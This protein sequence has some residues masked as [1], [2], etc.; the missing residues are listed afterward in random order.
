[1]MDCFSYY[2]ITKIINTGT[3]SQK[4]NQDYQ[5]TK[6]D[7]LNYLLQGNIEK[8]SGLR[9]ALPSVYARQKKVLRRIPGANL[10][11]R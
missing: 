4:D 3:T 8:P 11:S 2:L 6:K 5:N 10:P 9:H 7:N 1:I